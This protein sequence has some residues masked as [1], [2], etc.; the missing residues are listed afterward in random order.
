MLSVRSISW[1]TNETL[2][3]FTGGQLFEM[4]FTN[5]TVRQT[6]E[7]KARNYIE[8][9]YTPSVEDE[10]F[11]LFMDNGTFTIHS[12][13]RTH[14]TER[15]GSLDENQVGYEF[16]EKRK[17][18]EKP[19]DY[20]LISNNQL[21]MFFSQNGIVVLYEHRFA[22]ADTLAVIS[23]LT[24]FYYIKSSNKRIHFHREKA[25]PPMFESIPCGFIHQNQVYLIDA[26]NQVV[27]QFSSKSF[28]QPEWAA[29]FSLPYTERSFA[30]FFKCSKSEEE[31][32][33]I[34]K[35]IL[36]TVGVYWIFTCLGCAVFCIRPQ[37]SSTRSQT[38]TKSKAIQS[39]Q[40]SAIRSLTSSAEISNTTSS[41]RSSTDPMA[42]KIV[43]A[44]QCVVNENGDANLATKD[45]SPLQL[46]Q[47]NIFA[48]ILA[49][50]KKKKNN[51]DQILKNQNRTSE[52]GSNKFP[53]IKK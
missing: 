31:S 11:Y 23:N 32:K 27:L 15:K 24:N 45:F 5:Q 39:V 38:K 13:N 8:N 10:I 12:A 49:K 51:F 1:L 21:L 6:S 28:E 47:F 40:S 3:L 50:N 26:Q 35:I 43:K 42:A 17:I 19:T 20:R 44:V 9:I 7:N 4:T 53:K 30:D 2:L 34:V 36:I 33:A 18:T 22:H 16:V 25:A 48:K 46:R 14:I 29:N 52:L 41:S 37:C